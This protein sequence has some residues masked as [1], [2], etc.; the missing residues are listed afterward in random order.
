M[1]KDIKKSNNNKAV[2]GKDTNT[3][4][5]S[6]IIKAAL[7]L[8]LFGVI[9]IVLCTTFIFFQA[10]AYSPNRFEKQV[11]RL[12]NA[13]RRNYGL[14]PLSW[15]TPLARAARDHSEDM[16]ENS[17]FSHTGYDGSSVSERA[18][19]RGVNARGVGENIAMGQRTPEQV[20]AT[21]MNSAGHRANILRESS[22]H[23]GVGFVEG[24][25][26]GELFW[27]QKFATI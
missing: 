8:A 25:G 13:E 7:P 10:F 26:S 22:T 16:L 6:V 5:N 20:V 19:R 1:N 12:T 23:L 24:S 21:W 18:R 27:T 2:K 9:A 3:V 17:F 11:L 4:S 15:Y 14:S